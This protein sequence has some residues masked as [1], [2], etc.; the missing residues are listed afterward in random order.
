MLRFDNRVWMIDVLRDNADKTVIPKSAKTGMSEVMYLKMFYSAQ[1]GLSGMYTI[2]T[3]SLKNRVISARI[4]P[5]IA[6]VPYYR[7]NIS[8]N[9]KDV[10]SKSLKTMFGKVWNF[11]G[12]N[13]EKEFYEFDAD[14]ILF[15]ELDQCDQANLTLAMDRLGGTDRVRW[16]KIG[17]PTIA[18]FGIDAEFEESDK[19]FWFVKCG[20]CNEWQKLDWFIHFIN[21]EGNSQY[22]LKDERQTSEGDARP[23]CQKCVRPFDRLGKG[24]W[25][26]E[27]PDRDVSG[28][29]IS[30]LFGFPG[31]DN[32]NHIRQVIR[33]EFEL[34]NKAQGNPGLLQIFYN[35]RLGICY[36][37]KGAYV[38]RELIRECSKDYVMPQ[39]ATGCSMGVDVGK[40]YHCHISKVKRDE[41]G[42]KTR[43]KVFIGHVKTLE[44]VENLEK[45]YGVGRLVVDALPEL[46]QIREFVR[47]KTGRFACYSNKGDDKVEEDVS[48]KF[49][50]RV[51]RINKTESLDASLA[52]HQLGL[53]EY[54]KNYM[55]LDNGDF[56]AQMEAPKRIWNEDKQRYEWNEGGRPDHHR[57]ADNYDKVAADM[58]P[59]DIDILWFG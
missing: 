53:V 59:G 35:N 36:S 13:S 19:K 9:R 22:S 45:Q 48:K 20:H 50:D 32:P 52:D 42:R 31:N 56:I 6:R 7:D 4:D 55:T 12:A 14:I 58:H 17:N 47:A 57:H 41:H 37:A 30:R 15:D 2:P 23:I 40:V 27:Y 10:D 49:K 8:L 21:D 1:S 38:S 5:I 34:W 18:G 3:I 46:H 25:V 11:V 39:T 28:Y 16:M 54:P 51:V 44:D 24:N 26:A 43:Q 29:H 33:E